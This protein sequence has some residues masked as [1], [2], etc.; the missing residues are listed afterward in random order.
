VVVYFKAPLPEQN[1]RDLL[2]S[3]ASIGASAAGFMLTAASILVTL[4]DSWYLKRIKQAGVYASLVSSLLIAMSW[5]LVT[6][7]I[8][9]VGL[10]YDPRWHF[11][12]YRVAMTLWV[13]VSVA[14][15]ATTARVI[16]TFSTLLL[17]ISRES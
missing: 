13:I 3:A 15:L 16:R 7:V 12:W 9:G 11:G 6:A 2:S 17:L 8:S 5:S 10:L 4:R 14:A 1:F